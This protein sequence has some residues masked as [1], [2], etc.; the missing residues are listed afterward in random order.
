MDQPAVPEEEAHVVD[1]R[2]LRS[3][4]AWAEEDKVGR[5]QSRGLDLLATR[6]LAG[7]VRG[8]ATAENGLKLRGSRV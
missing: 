2:R 5:D 1:L 8:G 3:W 7:H 6:N 4:P